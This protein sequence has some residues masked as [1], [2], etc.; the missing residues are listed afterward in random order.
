M[1]RRWLALSFT[2]VALSIPRVEAR[3][4]DT[5]GAEG[6]DADGTGEDLQAREK[7]WA[8]RLGYPNRRVDP[9]WLTEA[10]RQDARVPRAVRILDSSQRTFRSPL[11]LDASR[12]TSLGP[13]PLEGD[14]VNHLSGRVNVIAIDPVDG[15]VAYFGAVGGGVWK[16]SN[17]CSAATT[18]SPVTDDPRLSSIAIADITIDPGNHAVL[19]A[20]TGDKV[21]GQTTLTATGVLKSTDQ[22]ATWTVQGEEVFG[23]AYPTPPGVTPAFQAVIKVRVDPRNSNNVVAGTRTGLYF[24]YDGGD[25]WSGPCTT[26]AFSTQRQ[27]VTGLLVS[28]NGTSTDLYAAIG[29][30][31]LSP[32]SPVDSEQNGANGVYKSS[33]PASGCPAAW[34]PLTRG[35]PKGTARGRPY[36]ANLLG[37]IDLAMAPG[38]PRTIYAQVQAVGT[39]PFQET[40]VGGQLGVW[41]TTDGGLTWTRRSGPSGLTGCAGDSTQNSWNQ[42]IA[43]D[44][45]DP[46]VVF[47]DTIDLYK[48]T[49]GGVTFLNQTCAYH[50]GNVHADQHAIEFVPGSSSAMLIGN[51]GGV[52]FTDTADQAQVT[53]SQ[54]NDTVSTIEFYG[55]DIT[56][57]FANSASPGVSAGSQ[58]NGSSVFV[59][60]GA[61]GPAIWREVLGGDGYHARIEPKQAQRWYQSSIV[62]KLSIS[63]TGPYGT[64]YALN[65]RF[66]REKKSVILP[67]EIDKFNC[68]GAT[69]DHLVLGTYRVWEALNGGLTESDWV[70]VSGVLIKDAHNPAAYVNA[71]AFAPTDGSVVAAAINDGGVHYGTG[72]GTGAM[73]TWT[74]LTQGNATLP[75]RP[76]LDVVI[77]PDSA[78]RVYAVAGGFDQN[79]PATPGHVFLATC[80]ADCRNPDS[81]TWSDK[82]GNL[83][84]IPVQTIEANPRY[85]R[86]VFVGTDWGLYFTNDIRAA[87][88]AW[89]KFSAGLPS[90]MIME[91]RIDRGAGADPVASSTTLAMFTRGRGAYVWPLPDGP[92]FFSPEIFIDG[93]EGGDTAAWS[94]VQP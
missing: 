69:C 89:V 81:W 11:G 3:P 73:G 39:A 26:N 92:I 86:Q 83:P 40:Q 16:T 67:Y 24:S 82:T 19:Y 31:G 45:N 72:L 78:G 12:A 53:F 47:L 87:E 58:D 18:W 2:L 27:D 4:V 50:G 56:G 66:A 32:I 49:D 22:G 8:Y 90:V 94:H 30:S 14:G 70:P 37:R 74:D 76:I 41:R 93:F 10:A 9:S 48:S 61:P 34:A 1:T 62:R 75:D 44:P 84:N 33:F 7:F 91:L 51:D 21:L 5:G 80:A 55:G 54:L 42:G 71:L 85:P 68:P 57:D 15:N 35:W 79:T 46:D 28:D 20:G 43:V 52:Y 25:T 29:I 38:D 60:T 88:P 17:C 64:Q 36:P 77:A 23:A 63:T 65:G 6:G 13:R 59:W